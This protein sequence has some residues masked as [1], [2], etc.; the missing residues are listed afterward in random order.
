[1]G[2]LRVTNRGWANGRIA[3]SGRPPLPTMST[4]AWAGGWRRFCGGCLR[5]KE[6]QM[7][8]PAKARYRPGMTFR[9]RND[10]D[11][12]SLGRWVYLLPLAPPIAAD[13]KRTLVLVP[14]KSISLIFES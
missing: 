1:M 13:P 2:D 6:S 10:G 14:P 5:G 4:V 11:P 9:P 7:A 12:P 8:P 3:T